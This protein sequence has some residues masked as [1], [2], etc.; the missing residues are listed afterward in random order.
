MVMCQTCTDVG[1][2]LYIDSVIPSKTVAVPGDTIAI[3]VT[4]RNTS[5]LFYHWMNIC[6]IDNLYGLSQTSDRFELSPTC[7]FGAC[8]NV[9][10]VKFYVT[11]PN[12]NVTF[13]ASLI[14]EEA[15]KCEATKQTTVYKDT[16]AVKHRECVSNICT[17]VPGAGTD[18][19]S[20]AGVTCTTPTRYKCISNQCQG[21]QQEGEFGS[22]TECVNSC[23]ID[24]GTGQ[25]ASDQM[26]IFG[27]CM[28]KNDVM[29]AG[30]AIVG[31]FILSR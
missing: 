8:N 2:D 13:T 15:S 10:Q 30:A 12:G 11:M 9:K 16:G 23:S 22:Y 24:G 6:L 31:F 26:K 3:T 20:A 21:P 5:S 1:G 17:D 18:Q 29:L 19:C 14:E 28:N 7:L 4:A 25:C 27:Q